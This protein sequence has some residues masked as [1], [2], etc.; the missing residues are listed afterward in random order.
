MSVQAQLWVLVGVLGTISYSALAI[1]A[2]AL[3]QIRSE[4]RELGRDLRVEIRQ[5][6]A[7]V[8]QVDA[9][10][11]QLDTSLRGEIRS[12]GERLAAAGG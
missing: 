9:R 2:T 5:V 1:L 12:L 7:R 6:E 8:G 10:V 11:G 4:V 3:F